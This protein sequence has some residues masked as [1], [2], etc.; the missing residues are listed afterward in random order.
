MVRQMMREVRDSA[1]AILDRTTLADSLKR[2]RT[3]KARAKA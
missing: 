2:A 1:A 3:R